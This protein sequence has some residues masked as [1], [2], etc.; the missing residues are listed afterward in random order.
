VSG[1]GNPEIVAAAGKGHSPEVK[2]FDASGHELFSFL[3]F[4]SG[5]EG[6]LSVAAGDLDGD[7]RAEIVVGT[8]TPP[9]RIRVFEGAVRRGPD[10]APFAP[11][12]PGVEVGV[13]DLAGNGDGSRAPQ[14]GTVHVWRSSIPRAARCCG[15]SRSTR[16]CRTASA[17]RAEI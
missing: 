5:Y 8:L 11:N 7:G 1:D 15:P 2:V 14:P 4:D 3:A 6:G 17:L 12:G 10:I 13:A 9:A 16:A